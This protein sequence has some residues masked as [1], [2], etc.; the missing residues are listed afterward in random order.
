MFAIRFY[1]M[2]LISAGLT[3]VVHI[4]SAT[5]GPRRDDRRVQSSETSEQAGTG[6]ES[7]RMDDGEISTKG[8]PRPE[9]EMG[10]KR[11]AVRS[12]LNDA[13]SDDLDRLREQIAIQ[14]ARIEEL[15]QALEEQRQFILLNLQFLR[16]RLAPNDPSIRLPEADPEGR[17]Y[18]G[19]N[20][21]GLDGVLAVS[22]SAPSIEHAASVSSTPSP[23]QAET[24]AK[25]VEETSRNLGGFKFSGD[26]RLRADIQLRSGN[27][28]GPPLQSAR[29]RYRLRLNIEKEI[30]PRFSFRLQ[31][32]TGALNS[33]TT[34]DQDFAGMVARHPFSISEAYVDFH[35][36][37]RLSLR[38]G[39]MEEVFA[40]GMRFLWDDDVRFNGFHQILTIPFNSSRFGV[41]ALQFRAGEYI[42]SNPNIV[43]LPASSPFVLAGYQPGQKVRA[44]KLFHPGFVIKGN[45]N[46]RWGHQFTSDIQIFLNPNQI[47]LATL[48]SG[49]PVLVSNA[50]G[51]AL[52][53][54][55]GARGNGT[56]TADGAILS[57][58][59]FQIVRAAYRLERNGL[60]WGS[61]E[62]PLWFD[63]QVA[64]NTGTSKLR[65]ALLA[66][67][68]LGAVRKYGD[69]RFLYQFALKDA[70]SLISQ[71]T[72]DD[73]GTGIGVNVATHALRFDLGLTRFL[74]WQNLF[75]IQNERRGNNPA[76]QFFVPLQ[77]EA[78]TTYR[79]L[80]Q[81]LFSF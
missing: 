11:D 32:A 5:A 66:S 65:D 69:T 6:K 54:P 55:I 26:F 9:V 12:R 64:R 80:G 45:V 58:R 1:V 51:I 48:P 30:D 31:L 18:P 46:E 2:L 73:I 47:Q 34:M 7:L 20:R 15:R 49:F 74:Q 50:L 61:R 76:E 75:F 79:Y 72:D 33:G 17:S 39:R 23:G 27:A 24:L 59:D 21:T 28:I 4:S 35:P 29:A 37:P 52:S 36:N 62:M 22:E 13:D 19:Q 38:A 63:L 60:M 42:L 3:L 78:K 8:R 67:V 14:G 56:T 41:H 53:G 77:R 57:A 70:N 10:T 16:E 43:I 81:L 71:F 68:N 44:A 40:D 25:K